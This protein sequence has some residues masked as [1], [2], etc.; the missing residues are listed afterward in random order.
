MPEHKLPQIDENERQL[1]DSLLRREVDAN[2]GAKIVFVDQEEVNRRLER[3]LHRKFALYFLATVYSE[4]VNDEAAETSSQ[5]END[6][7]LLGSTEPKSDESSSAATSSREFVANY[8]LG[9]VRNSAR[10]VPELIGYFAANYPQLTVKTSLLLNSK[11]INTLKISEYQRHVNATYL[12][13]TYRYGPLLQTSIVGVKNE[14][15]G[16]YFPEFIEQYLEANPFLQ[17]VMPW[18]SLSVNEHMKPQCSN[19]GPIIW[20][21]LIFIFCSFLCFI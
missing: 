10:H 6:A 12:N 7:R 9:V 2:G 1:F 4:S 21:R 8:A 5:K 11:E 20:A 3:A 16:D 17:P 18:G 14:E 15:I 13:G 19:D